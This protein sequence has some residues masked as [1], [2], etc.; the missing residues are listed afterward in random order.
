MTTNSHHIV[1]QK[2][3]IG[4]IIWGTGTS[5][6]GAIKDAIKWMDEYEPGLADRS[7]LEA[8]PCAGNLYEAILEIGGANVQWYLADN[9]KAYKKGRA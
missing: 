6:N 7:D 2:G 4:G 9:G 5:K 1:Y 3:D 8:T